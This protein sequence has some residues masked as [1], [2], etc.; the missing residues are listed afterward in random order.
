MYDSYDIRIDFKLLMMSLYLEYKVK[1]NQNDIINGISYHQQLG[2]LAILSHTQNDEAE[3]LICDELVSTIP[4]Y[5]MC[6]I[7]VWFNFSQG[8]TLHNSGPNVCKGRITSFSWHPTQ[9]TLAIGSKSGEICIW[10]GGLVT[11]LDSFH[12]GLIVFSKWSSLGG[13]LVTGDEVKI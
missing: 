7:M 10:N 1:T 9:R 11:A 6:T 2:L 13:C 3:I 8:E 12:E 4:L 5:P